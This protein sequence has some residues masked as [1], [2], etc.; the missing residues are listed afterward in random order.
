M[1]RG[2]VSAEKRGPA[3]K[4]P[5]VSRKGEKGKGA[6]ELRERVA[7]RGTVRVVPAWLPSLE[8]WA[9]AAMRAPMQSSDGEGRGRDRVVCRPDAYY[10]LPLSLSSLLCINR[11][12]IAN[13]ESG[14]G[15]RPGRL[16]ILSYPLHLAPWWLCARR[17]ST[18]LSRHPPVYYDPSRGVKLLK[19]IIYTIGIQAVHSFFFLEF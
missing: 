18:Y 2:K 19:Y 9:I 8:W 7:Q 11:G 3:T 14:V 1:L 6:R 13:P 16:Q 5:W 12:T 4:N 10:A 17:E 15:S